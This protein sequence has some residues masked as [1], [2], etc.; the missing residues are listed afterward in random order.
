[1]PQGLPSTWKDDEMMKVMME[2]KASEDSAVGVTEVTAT[3]G[4]LLLV[5]RLV[6]E[7]NPD[8]GGKSSKAWRGFIGLQKLDYVR[9]GNPSWGFH[10]PLGRQFHPLLLFSSLCVL[11]LN[12]KSKI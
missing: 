8:Y 11:L 5:P 12:F 3:G 7:G 4:L 10:I 2:E 1:M 9:K 6:S